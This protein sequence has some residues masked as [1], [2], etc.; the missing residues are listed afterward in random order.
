MGGGVEFN[1]LTPPGSATVDGAA[2]TTWTTH[3]SDRRTTET[4]GNGQKSP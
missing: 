4:T 1:L 3:G 2:D